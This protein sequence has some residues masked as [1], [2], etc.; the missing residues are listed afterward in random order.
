MAGRK[1]YWRDLTLRKRRDS[2][3]RRPS[4]VFVRYEIRPVGDLKARM[5]AVASNGREVQSVIQRD[6]EGVPLRGAD[7]RILREKVRAY[8]GDERPLGYLAPAITTND[9]RVTAKRGAFRSTFTNGILAAQWLR[10]V[11]NED[12]VIEEDELYNKIITPNDP[13]RNY[14][15]GDV[16]PLIREL[17]EREGTFFLSLY[18]LEDEELEKLLVDNADRIHVI[19]SNTALKDGEWDVRNKKGRERLIAAGVDIQHR[20]FNNSIHIG[21][22][23]FVVHVPPDGG[24][25]SVLTGSTNWTSTGLAG[26]TNNALL[27]EDDAVAAEFLSYWDLMKEDELPLPAP[28]GSP[29]KGNQ[30]S[31]EFRKANEAGAEFTLG[32]G[33]T[34][35]SGF[36]RTGP[37]AK[38]RLPKQS[39][40]LFRRI[41]LKYITE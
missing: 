15:A 29:M 2:M 4:E 27:V 20:M 6:S 12:G 32:N 11:L 33:A 38:N 39:Q 37:N 21:H 25:R 8:E 24:P 30:Q 19:L 41:W 22:N 31:K 1:A 36:H 7:G 18:E 23:K 40:H 14:L 16:I 28:L 17:F 3:T 26:Q 34:V 13:H 35:K 5:D 9:I 10:N